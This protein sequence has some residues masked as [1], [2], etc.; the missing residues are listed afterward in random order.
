MNVAGFEFLYI[1]QL[2]LANNTI[3]NHIIYIKVEIIGIFVR[4][5]L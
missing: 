3:I 4:I 5:F 1:Y 2:I